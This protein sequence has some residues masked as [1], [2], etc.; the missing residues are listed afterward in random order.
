MSMNLVSEPIKSNKILFD[1]VSI[2]HDIEK[3]KNIKKVTQ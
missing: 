3:K 2:I 1:K